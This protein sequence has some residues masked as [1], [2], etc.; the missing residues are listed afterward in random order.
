MTSLGIFMSAVIA[1]RR[2][3]SR[4]D[5][6]IPLGASPALLLRLRFSESFAIIALHLIKN[7]YLLAVS[8]QGA[9][10][11]ATFGWLFCC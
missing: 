10:P 9:N 5:D 3:G 8:S 2:H 7:D 4:Q 11:R 6:T 1:G